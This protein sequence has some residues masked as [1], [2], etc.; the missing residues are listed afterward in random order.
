MSRVVV[1][2][3][4]VCEEC[5]GRLSRKRTWLLTENTRKV[6]TVCRKCKAKTT[7]LE[8]KPALGKADIKTW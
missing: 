4:H 6:S 3:W 8:T 7:I 5:G 2:V 1:G